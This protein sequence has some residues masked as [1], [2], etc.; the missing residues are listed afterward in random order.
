M[1]LRGKRECR[2]PC[3]DIRLHQ[4]LL[5]RDPRGQPGR[6][7]GSCH[8]HPCVCCKG[9]HGGTHF[10][11]RDPSKRE[12]KPKERADK[13]GPVFLSFPLFQILCGWDKCPYH[14]N[15]TLT[16]GK[17]SNPA[18]TFYLQFNYALTLVKQDA[19]SNDI[20]SNSSQSETLLCLFC[21]SKTVVFFNFPLAK[22][23]KNK[24]VW[25]F[26]LPKF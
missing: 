15:V 3:S 26:L 16:R 14:L 21:S 13:P 24:W 6:W 4:L 17:A 25:G 22:G 20:Y 12:K 5:V 23:V 9:G 7:E 11:R 10:P 1:Q 2:V 18:V 19:H 8:H